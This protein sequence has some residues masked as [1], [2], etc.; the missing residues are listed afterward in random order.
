MQYVLNASRQSRQI[1]P[2]LAEAPVQLVI[3]NDGPLIES[4][5]YWD[6]PSPRPASST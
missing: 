1:N 5:N 3:R 2:I 4:T 6:S